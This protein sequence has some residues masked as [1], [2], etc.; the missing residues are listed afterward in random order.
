[1]IDNDEQLA[2]TLDYIAKLAGALEG[3]RLGEENKGNHMFAACASGFLYELRKNLD[4]TRDYANREVAKQQ[5]P[6]N[7]IYTN[8]HAT[9]KDLVAT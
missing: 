1:M 8:G 3:L 6:K 2:A 5:T 9:P 4:L 7:G